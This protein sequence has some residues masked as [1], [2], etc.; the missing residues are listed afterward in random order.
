MFHLILVD[1]SESSERKSVLPWSKIAKS[2]VWKPEIAGSRK[3]PR[4]HRPPPPPKHPKGLPPCREVRRSAEYCGDICRGNFWGAGWGLWGGGRQR[5]W[6]LMKTC[7]FQTGVT[8]SLRF[9]KGVGRRGLAT[10]MAKMLQKQ[11]LKIIQSWPWD[12]PKLL[13]KFLSSVCQNDSLRAGYPNRSS[14]IHR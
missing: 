6:Q 8:Q 13:R 4:F 3:L 1:A 9:G 7:I 2:Q 10:N 14:G 11:F 12:H 5:G